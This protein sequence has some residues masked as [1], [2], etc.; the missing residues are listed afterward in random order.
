M[1]KSVPIQFSCI[2][3]MIPAV[4]NHLAGLLRVVPIAFKH[5]RSLE[6]HF[7]NLT[8]RQF[9][10]GLGV[11]DLDFTNQY[12][13][14]GSPLLLSHSLIPESGEPRELARSVN[15]C[16]WE[17][18]GFILLDQF[19]GNKGT[20]GDNL[21]QALHFPLT[22]DECWQHEFEH[23][24]HGKHMGHPFLLRQFPDVNRVE[25]GH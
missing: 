11:D 16:Q 20:A 23:H 18:Q 14:D 5:L 12:F 10:P 17:A 22:F 4:P 3:R 21:P 1:E 8:C 7:P 24:R 6:Q 9:L 15:H 19:D 13:P 25:T 2:P